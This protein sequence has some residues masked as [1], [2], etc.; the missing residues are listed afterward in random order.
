MKI[1]DQLDELL[2]DAPEEEVQEDPSRSYRVI[3]VGSWV[4]V[5]RPKA[6]FKIPN[7]QS[8]GLV[9]RRADQSNV[10]VQFESNVV[11][12]MEEWFLG[13]TD[14]PSAPV[15]IGTPIRS[16]TISGTFV[17]CSSDG[18]V[19]IYDVD[20]GVAGLFDSVHVKGW[21]RWVR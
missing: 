16:H 11:L 3:Y 19:G 20:R 5:V 7:R 9:L 14:P 18:L 12:T 8:V 21:D 13:K 17:G 4:K 2:P 1:W 15:M 6:Q 10:I